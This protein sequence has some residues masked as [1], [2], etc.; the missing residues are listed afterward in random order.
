MNKTKQR[1]VDKSKELFNKHSYGRVT[2]RMI[3]TNLGMSS[4]N[5]NYHFKKREDIL[6]YIYFEMVSDFDKRIETLPETEISFPQIKNDIQSSMER[7]LKYKFIWTDL[8]NILKVNDKICDHFHK[9]YQKRIAGNVFLFNHLHERQLIRAA[10]FQDEYQILAE[11]MVNFGD[12]WIYTS[13]IYNKRSSKKHLE[14]QVNSML[15]MIYPYL[16][17]KGIQEF[18]KAF[19]RWFN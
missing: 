8:F 14:H 1:I 17:Q 19:P 4:G 13:E 5:L 16:T 12:T 7:M 15:A 11:R 2:I 6:E 10:N 9:V 18:E 3:A